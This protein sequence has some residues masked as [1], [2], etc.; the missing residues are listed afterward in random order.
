VFPLYLLSVSLQLTF[1]V[2]FRIYLSNHSMATAIDSPEQVVPNEPCNKQAA[3]CNHEDDPTRSGANELFH[4]L[5]R[6]ATDDNT[7]SLYGFRRYRTTH[8][9]NLRL[10]EHEIDKMDHHL[11]QAGLRLSALPT[12]GQRLGLKYCRR[13]TSFG[14]QEG[15][16]AES[17]L[18]LRALIKQYGMSNRH[19]PLFSSAFD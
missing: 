2:V 6:N 17:M 19:W 14:A 9:L 4:K 11:F 13:D 1:L 5:W 10:L 7:L 8:L 3:P 16:P 18:Q 12:T 15:V